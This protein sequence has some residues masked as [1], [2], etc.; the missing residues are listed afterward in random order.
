MWLQPSVGFA[1]QSVTETVQC[2]T[3]LKGTFNMK[4]AVLNIL[5]T[6][7]NG[8]MVALNAAVVLAILWWFAVYI[9]PNLTIF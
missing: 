1:K 7:G 9:W 3:L 2:W 5:Y 8:I 4:Q 6:I